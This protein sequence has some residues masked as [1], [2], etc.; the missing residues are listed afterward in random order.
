MLS[1]PV[2]IAYMMKGDISQRAIVSTS[3]EHAEAWVEDDD[4]LAH[5]S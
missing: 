5:D 4:Q 1:S 2:L 3:E